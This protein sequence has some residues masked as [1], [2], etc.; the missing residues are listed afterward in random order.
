MTLCRFVNI[1]GWE[2]AFDVDASLP[3]TWLIAD[4]PRLPVFPFREDALRESKMTRR[5]FHHQVVRSSH[6]AIEHVYLEDD[7]LLSTIVP[8]A[9]ADLQ[10]ARLR[11]AQL[12]KLC[13]HA[14]DA[15]EN[16][17]LAFDRTE[18]WRA[19][20]RCEH[21]DCREHPELGYAC[22]RATPDRGLDSK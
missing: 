18:A 13:E 1:D 3:P 17:V 20:L 2:H 10:L 5:V 16:P 12:E 9:C 7:A 21:D 19:M 11:I 4:R 22:R 8:H 6:R 15:L 14:L